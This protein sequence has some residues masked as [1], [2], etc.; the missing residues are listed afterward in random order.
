MDEAV[1]LG[2]LKE[3]EHLVQRNKILKHERE[4]I[5]AWQ[6]HVERVD[7]GDLNKNIEEVLTALRPKEGRVSW[8][9]TIIPQARS[10]GKLFR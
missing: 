3:D 7:S 8:R 5:V 9:S 10:A 1:K 6:D 2:V 4:A